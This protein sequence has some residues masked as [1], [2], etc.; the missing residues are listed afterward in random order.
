MS[1]KLGRRSLPKS[2][3]SIPKHSYH[4][5]HKGPALR[6]EGPTVI[7]KATYFRT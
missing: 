2:I 5:Y 1:K 3:P 6:A 7:F 4:P